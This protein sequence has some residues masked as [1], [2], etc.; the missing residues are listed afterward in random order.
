MIWLFAAALAGDTVILGNS[1]VFYND[2]PAALD[3]A[4]TEG[5]HTGQVSSLTAG[6]LRLPEHLAR[7]NGADTGWAQAFDGDSWDVVVLQDQ[8]QVPGFPDSNARAK[9]T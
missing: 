4:L 3:T 6:G 8:S 5:G 1:Y 2:L 9:E 7:I